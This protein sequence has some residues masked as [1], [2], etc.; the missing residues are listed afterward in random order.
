MPLHGPL[1]HDQIAVVLRRAAELDRDLGRGRDQRGLDEE[2][3]EQAAVEAGLSLPAVRRA[4]AEYRAG[5][6]D[7]T[8]GPPRRRLLGP[9]VL[10]VT[11]SVPG[12]VE[13]VERHLHG[14]LHDQLFEVRRDMG[15]RTTWVRRRSLEA[16]TRRAIDRAVHRRLCLREVNHLDVSVVGDRDG[17]A[18]VRLD[19]DV[20]AARHAQGGAAGSGAVVGG[21]LAVA[22]G[23]AAVLAHPAFLV[24]ASAGLG[25]A[26]LGHWAGTRMYSN[27]VAIIESF[28]AGELDR[29]ERRDRSTGERH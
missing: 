19:V 12:P 3:V 23:T 9:A 18:L 13:E 1:N 20:V 16:T 25:V 24:A 2:A 4:L 10:T 15:T 26:G 22:G 29:L 11:R 5:L 28:L 27:R 7:Q 14:F 21:G 17:W 6:L 8:D